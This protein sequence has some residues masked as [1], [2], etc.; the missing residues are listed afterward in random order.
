MT[1]PPP[2]PPPLPNPLPAPLQAP[3]QETRR[4]RVAERDFDDD[5]H[6]ATASSVGRMPA[7]RAIA[8]VLVALVA[9]AFLDSHAFVRAGEAMPEG[10]VRT[11][12]LAVA[13]PVDAVAGALGLRLPSEALDAAFGNERK[14]GDGA[15]SRLDELADGPNADGSAAPAASAPVSAGATTG[16]DAAPNGAAA[17]VSTAPGATASAGSSAPAASAV[18]AS[19]LPAS[20]LPAT[21]LPGVVVGPAGTGP[22]RHPTPGH[23]LKVLVTGD[24]LSD[25]VGFQMAAMTSAAGL[26]QIENVPRNGTGL[27]NPDF[28]D[29]SVNAQQEIAARKPDVVV[30][31]MGGNDG[32][33]LT[34]GGHAY[35]AGSPQWQSAYARRIAAVATILSGGGARPVYWSTPPFPESS[36]WAR[37]FASQARA[38]VAAVR[39]VPGARYVD[40]FQ[41]TQVAGKY[42]DELPFHGQLVDARQPDGIHFSRIGAKIPAEVILQAMAADVG[43]V[44]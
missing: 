9:A 31:V 42:S 27:T 8:V 30:V 11:V 10:A 40:L 35:A 39:S 41:R 38:A 28:F 19:G 34:V 2:L 5:A 29:W 6:P 17:P 21:V 26:V 15:T 25:F 32:W 22:W 14:T 18:P 20:G 7:G 36:K 43:R 16:G 33:N 44:R 13:H 4:V 12:T 24:S 37:I 3:L 23:P 1:A